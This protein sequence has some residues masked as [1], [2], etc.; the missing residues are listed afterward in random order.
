[1]E[2]FF[3]GSEILPTCTDGSKPPNIQC[4]NS[5]LPVTVTCHSYL[6]QLPCKVTVAM[7]QTG[8]PENVV[9]GSINN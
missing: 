4:F 9:S 2:Q 8:M 5:Q 1:M 3:T 6:S 7:I